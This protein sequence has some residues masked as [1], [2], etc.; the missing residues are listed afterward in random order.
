MVVQEDVGLIVAVLKLQEG[1][2]VKCHKYYPE[3]SSEED[4]DF[5]GLTPG[6]KVEKI[7]E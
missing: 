4:R 5:Q 1:G 7:G 6:V 3:V 2:R